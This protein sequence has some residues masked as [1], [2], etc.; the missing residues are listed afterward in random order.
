[1]RCGF[2]ADSAA[3]RY[4]IL[5]FTV[6][7]PSQ[8]PGLVRSQFRRSLQS[9]GLDMHFYA[10]SSHSSAKTISLGGELYHCGCNS[11]LHGPKD[12]SYGRNGFFIKM[13]LRGGRNTTKHI[14]PSIPCRGHRSPSCAPRPQG[15]SRYA[16]NA[17]PASPQSEQRS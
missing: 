10:R 13:G 7:H 5:C 15:A 14:H 4:E 8:R 2:R 3:T 17:C 9:L 12:G 16:S 11:H 6:F 1:M